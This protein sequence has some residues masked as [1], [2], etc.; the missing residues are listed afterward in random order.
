MKFPWNLHPRAPE[1]VE[2]WRGNF[3]PDIS[4]PASFGWQWL[5]VWAMAPLP[6]PAHRTGLAVLLHP[7]PGQDLTPSPTA[8]RTPRGQPHEPADGLAR[9]KTMTL[10]RMS[11][12]AASCSISCQKAS[13]VSA[14]TGSR[15]D[16]GTP[17][18]ALSLFPRRRKA[19]MQR[20][21]QETSLQASA[22]SAIER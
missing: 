7:A 11:S 10:A 22:A 18:A 13:T 4:V 19:G 3:R 9:Y 20:W 5:L 16:S 12:S 8:A 15:R 6:H 21:V 17:I 14:I 1:M 2:M